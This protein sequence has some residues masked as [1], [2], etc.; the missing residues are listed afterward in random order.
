VE[1]FVHTSLD[2]YAFIAITASFSTLCDLIKMVKDDNNQRQQQMDEFGYDALRI[3]N[4][5][6]FL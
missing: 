5:N 4:V 2:F 1:A 3:I 6:V